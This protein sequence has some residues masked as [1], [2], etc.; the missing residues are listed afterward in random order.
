MQVRAAKRPDA[1]P[2]ASGRGRGEAAG[3][4]AGRAGPEVPEGLRGRVREARP[5]RGN[6]LPVARLLAAGKSCILGA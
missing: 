2:R 6:F 3:V 5:V 4:A 1:S